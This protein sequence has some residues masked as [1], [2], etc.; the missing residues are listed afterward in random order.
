M[1]YFCSPTRKDTFLLGRISQTVVTD[2]MHFPKGNQ[3]QAS[4]S[5]LG[6]FQDPFSQLNFLYRR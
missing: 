2:F 4:T 6:E 5:S 1:Y 3:H